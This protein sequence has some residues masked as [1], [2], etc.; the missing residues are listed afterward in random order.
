[1]D[2]L[3][4]LFDELL[5]PAAD[6]GV[7]VT[8]V[9][10]A[11]EPDVQEFLAQYVGK[12]NLEIM[13]LDD[14]LGVAK[15]RNR[16]FA[17]SQRECIVYLDDDSMIEMEELASVPKLFD[18]Y[19]DAG[20]LAFRVV[21][22]LTGE[23]QNGQEACKKVV[24]NFHGAGHAIRRSLIQKVG[25]LD[26]VCFFGAEELEFTMRALVGGMTTV[27]IPEILVKHY[28]LMRT[29]QNLLQ[30]RIFW[31][32]NYAM[33][34]FRYLPVMTATLFGCRLFI[35]YLFSGI[36]IIKIGVALLPPMMLAGAFMGLRSRNPLNVAGVAFYSDPNI[37]PEL[38]NVSISS[39]VLRRL[40]R[41]A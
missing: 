34:L 32:R 15:G 7:Q 14:N 19:P 17:S 10:N 38:G 33:V 6:L 4:R 16:G 9:D 24:G 2:C 13:L 18:E 41:N 30:R 22:G 5:L 35:S 29:G 21:H 37:R 28:S 40:R 8:V 11:S 36:K 39:K 26:E 23:A 12:S 27:Y 3:P 1:M 20:I 31:A 25:Y